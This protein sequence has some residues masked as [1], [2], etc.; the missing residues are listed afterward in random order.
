MPTPPSGRHGIPVR[1]DGSLQPIQ[2]QPKSECLQ[3]PS[4][5]RKHPTASPIL[6]PVLL[7]P[8]KPP[9]GSGPGG[10][11]SPRHGLPFT[12][13]KGGWAR[14]DREGELPAGPM[15][16][17]W[18]TGMDSKLNLDNPGFGFLSQSGGKNGLPAKQACVVQPPP[19]VFRWHPVMSQPSSPSLSAAPSFNHAGLPGTAPA[20]ASTAMWGNG[21]RVLPSTA[22]DP[23]SPTSGASEWTRTPSKK[24][25]AEEHA[26]GV[27]ARNAAY[28]ET[29]G[30]LAREMAPG[31]SFI[32]RASY[33]IKRSPLMPPDARIE[34]VAF[35][36][37]E[38][39]FLATVFP[40]SVPAGRRDVHY[41]RRWL[42]KEIFALGESTLED[43]HAFAQQLQAVF[44]VGYHELMRQVATTSTDRGQLMADLWISYVR[45]IRLIL[46]EMKDAPASSSS[47]AASSNDPAL[48]RHQK[49]RAAAEVGGESPQRSRPGQARAPPSEA[50]ASKGM[51]PRTAGAP[52][53]SGTTGRATEAREDAGAGDSS[54]AA[55][56]GPTSPARTGDTGDGAPRLTPRLHNRSLAFSS[57]MSAG[58][59]RPSESG[60]DMLGSLTAAVRLG[61]GSLGDPSEAT[62]GG[63]G[64]PHLRLVEERLAAMG[65]TLSQGDRGGDSDEE[66][67]GGGAR[68]NGDEASMS[69]EDRLR[70]AVKQ[71]KRGTL[72]M[73]SGDALLDS[74][75][76]VLKLAMALAARN[77]LWR[78][79]V[80]GLAHRTGLLS[81]ASAGRE[82]GAA[83][84]GAAAGGPTQ[85]D[86]QAQADRIA[87][88]RAD[89]QKKEQAFQLTLRVM[90]RENAAARERLEEE[91]EASEGSVE[92][93]IRRQAAM[94]KAH[95]ATSGCIPACFHPL[96]KLDASRHFI[97]LSTFPESQPL[98]PRSLLLDIISNVLAEK[99][100]VL[101][102]ETTPQPMHVFLYK[103]LVAKFGPLTASEPQLMQLL[104]SVRRYLGENPKVAVFARMIGIYRPLPQ[105]GQDTLVFLVKCVLDQ[106]NDP[107]V[108]ED[109]RQSEPQ[110]EAARMAAYDEEMD[111]VALSAANRAIR[112]ALGS[113]LNV[114]R[115]LKEVDAGARAE[116]ARVLEHKGPLDDDTL[117][118]HPLKVDIGALMHTVLKHWARAYRDKHDYLLDMFRDFDKDN[119]GI[120]SCEEFCELGQRVN[121]ALSNDELL[122][123][124][125]HA[126]QSCQGNDMSAGAFVRA[127]MAA[128]AIPGLKP[129]IPRYTRFQPNRRSTV[130]DGDAGGGSISSRQLGEQ[131]LPS[132]W[133]NI[134][135]KLQLGAQRADEEEVA[136]FGVSALSHGRPGES[137]EG[138]SCA[139]WELPPLSEIKP[140][141]GAE[142][143]GGGG[144]ADEG[145]E[146]GRTV[147]TLRSRWR[148]G[149]SKAGDREEECAASSIW[150]KIAQHALTSLAPWVAAQLTLL[151]KRGRSVAK[152]RIE[153]DLDDIH[154][155]AG[156]A[157]LPEGGGTLLMKKFRSV[158]ADIIR[159]VEDSANSK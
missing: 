93:D 88:M 119:R 91:I 49:T 20:G 94:D 57:L 138:G 23:L 145:A 56:D 147:S 63:G 101:L 157:R 87:R 137:V 154:T 155:M 118:L 142:A 77:E 18:L 24:N 51:S 126:S 21:A 11:P 134:H 146:G 2:I 89:M 111:W 130:G 4:A 107:F 136:S 92:R 47:N 67:E 121:A 100:A 48:D 76:T 15:S 132:G 114:D 44:S 99:A 90:E 33:I 98:M 109:G 143:G 127:M 5:G 86:M 14:G 129:P 124:Y 30:D 83:A 41:L 131:E 141:G 25:V 152:Q 9:K 60:M 151:T 43:P 115:I 139:M 102:G 120:F 16:L 97:N 64:S 140:G 28:L 158:V 80:H 22:R 17:P 45:A 29:S 85:V 35:S 40:S 106:P 123:I 153:L 74:V 26:A 70:Y 104:A 73:E 19:I 55:A 75:E 144:G 12:D 50:A 117:A 69:L 71:A 79:R 32:P 113:D 72:H 10:L 36:K 148:S 6:S 54:D 108:T 105:D 13:D 95:D 150:V 7:S 149:S 27:S 62:G 112:M 84:G 58:G 135:L 42:E 128:G 96:L 68:P 110:R 156:D 65:V 52:P 34:D 122:S 103:Y 59:S 116:Q 31:P 82:P 78:I 66:V 46:Q 81:S 37:E 1:P 39:L 3:P 53:A 8:V 133:A 38:N 125:L 61:A 159:E